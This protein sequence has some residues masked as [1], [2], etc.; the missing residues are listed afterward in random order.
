MG[1]NTSTIFSVIL[2]EIR[3]LRRKGKGK[4]RRTFNEVA[5]EL[6]KQGHLNVKGDTFTGDTVKGILHRAKKR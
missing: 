1:C 5:E 4:V 6:N 2:R 3:R